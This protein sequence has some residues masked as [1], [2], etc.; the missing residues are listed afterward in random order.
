FTFDPATAVV[1]DTITL[2]DHGLATGAE[3]IYGPGVVD[4]DGSA[5]LAPGRLLSGGTYYA[6]VISDD[7]IQ[8]ALTLDAALADLPDV[9]TPDA[10][11]ATG[12][13]HTLQTY[14]YSADA[15]D[16][17]F[18]F[19]FTV[20]ERTRFIAYGST[21]PEIDALEAAETAKYFQL[22][23]FFSD[24]G[25]AVTFDPSYVYTLSVEETTAISDGAVLDPDVLQYSLAKG[26]LSGTSDTEASDEAPN[27]TGVN[28]T[29]IAGGGVGRDEDA[30]TIDL[31]GGVAPLSEAEKIVLA[32]AEAD[33]MTLDGDLLTVVPRQDVD[34]ELLAQGGS[35]GELNVSALGRVFLGSE[36]DINIDEVDSGGNRIRI[37]GQ[38]GVF[39][40]AL[41]A[42]QA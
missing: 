25:E 34:V 23:T 7:A 39:N 20:E 19:S 28:V 12:T 33:D 15:Y 26:I 1:G 30:V 29:L 6:V 40:V 37:K 27:V 4:S 13:S 2:P 8:L 32:S 17:D 11:E 5:A 18:A 38:Y 42:T 16:P 41:L 14:A 3:V 10:A 22:H 31:S 9:I 36:V 35:Q 24:R 21:E